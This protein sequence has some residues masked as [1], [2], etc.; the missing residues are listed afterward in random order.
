MLTRYNV[1][2]DKEGRDVKKTVQFESTERAALM[3]V[4]TRLESAQN[5]LLEF[6]ESQATEWWAFG[7]GDSMGSRKPDLKHL[8]D[9]IR[10]LTYAKGQGRVESKIFPGVICVPSN[11]ST[12]L[13]EV[14]RL[15]HELHL[16]AIS[17]GDR[18]KSV[19]SDRRD[20][21]EVLTLFRYALRNARRGH[22][23]YWQA[24]RKLYVLT[25]PV[26]SI[27]FVWYR[28]Y[29]L[30]KRTV[31]EV[32]EAMS[33]ERFTGR[34]AANV[35]HDLEVLKKLSDTQLL[36]R[37]VDLPAHPRANVVS[38][39]PTGVDR[40]MVRASLPLIV[41]GDRSPKLRAL[42]AE[43]PTKDEMRQRPSVVLD[44][45]VSFKHLD[46]FLYDSTKSKK[47]TKSPKRTSP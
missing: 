46:F 16:Q 2:T 4:L 35:A 41:C 25:A 38:E 10:T 3:S 24:S 27:S 43:P 32:K 37:R 36:F 15:R 42:Q 31:A 14:N 5:E 47:W 29:E 8:V 44:S 26:R 19:Y 9:G 11:S 33:Q 34:I 17:M 12:L 21:T 7:K 28:T 6:L 22:L 23:N 18:R 20:R 13:A 1:S 40:T 30:E 39:T 45:S